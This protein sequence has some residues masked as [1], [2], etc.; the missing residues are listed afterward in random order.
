[1]IGFFHDLGK[2]IAWHSNIEDFGQISPKGRM[3][4]TSAGLRQNSDD[5]R[6]RI[7]IL[8]RLR[9]HYEPVVTGQIAKTGKKQRV[10]IRLQLRGSFRQF[11]FVVLYEGCN[12]RVHLGDDGLDSG[13]LHPYP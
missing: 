8:G 5:Q 7:E 12:D 13:V 6:L 10:S 11:G 1:M 4:G 2:R 3:S 9:L